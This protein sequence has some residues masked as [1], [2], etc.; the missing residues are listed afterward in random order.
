MVL[1]VSFLG[2]LSI[3]A[4]VFL[5]PYI[6]GGNYMDSTVPFVVLMAANLIFLISLPVHI[7]ILYYFSYPK[8]FVF[9]SFTHLLLVGILGWFLIGG[10][11][12]LGASLTV[13]IGNIFNFIIPLVWVLIKIRNSK[14]GS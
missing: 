6:Y 8:L 5:I 3:P 7:S 4:V 9:L 10:F 14:I 11:K 2:L 12:V 1:G 13:L